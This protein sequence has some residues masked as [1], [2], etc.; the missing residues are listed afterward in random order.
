MRTRVLGSALALVLL[1]TS[2]QAESVY[3]RGDP[4]GYLGVSGLVVYDDR[5]DLRFWDYGSSDH[6]SDGGVAA[7]AGIRMGA[8]L[9]IELQGDWNHL[10][11]WRRDDL[12]A[13][14]TNFR[15]Y[16]VQYFYEEPDYDRFQPY[17][18]AGV[19]V[20]G[21][22]TKGDEYQLNG[23]FRTGLGLDIYLTEQLAL[24]LGYEWVTGTGFW[25]EIDSRNFLFGMQFTFAGGEE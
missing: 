24:S 15:A 7:R 12:W 25:S 16:P 23:A 13:I 9:A 18:V 17:V 14:T 3:G 2:V 19:G 11:S 4:A 6:D 8:P 10:R 1:A 22:D 5:E 20:V 21:G